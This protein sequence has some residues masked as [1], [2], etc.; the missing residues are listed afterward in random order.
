MPAR[1][2]CP[3]AHSPLPSSCSQSIADKR[4]RLSGSGPLSVDSAEIQPREPGEAS[5]FEWNP[6][7]QQVAAE[8][9]S[10]QPGQLPQRRGV[11]PGI[12]PLSEVLLTSRSDSDSRPATS[13][14]SAGM[15]P[16]NPRFPVTSS[17]R[18]SDSVPNSGGS[19]PNS[20]LPMNSR[21]A[22]SHPTE[23]QTRDAA[24]RV[25]LDPVPFPRACRRAEPQTSAP[26]RV[27][28]P[29]F[30]GHGLRR[31]RPELTRNP[32]SSGRDTD[33]RFR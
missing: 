26:P 11:E 9:E 22:S 7:T 1:P 17:R 29:I 32:T 15:R 19:D 31:G 20:P 23:T 21:A 25:S 33:V 16:V 30:L 4:V 28:K 13:S 8:R 3:G 2:A 24:L 14:N 18:R 6:S 5:Q 12:E 27:V 10:L